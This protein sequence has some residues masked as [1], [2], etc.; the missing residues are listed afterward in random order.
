[1]WSQHVPP[2]CQSLAAGLQG[3]TTQKTTIRTFYV[4][5][6]LDSK[7]VQWAG[8]IALVGRLEMCIEFW[9]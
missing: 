1:M 6:I 3:V 5:S 8:H 7:D 9:W 2:E 4:I